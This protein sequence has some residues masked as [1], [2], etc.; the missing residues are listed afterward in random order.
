MRQHAI[1][2]QTKIAYAKKLL[3]ELSE[4]K[5]ATEAE[6]I[7]NLLAVIATEAATAQTRHLAYL[8]QFAR[9]FTELMPELLGEK[10][11]N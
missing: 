3:K 6:Q 9:N 10:A 7:G 8:E 1:T 2:A 4:A 11:G 5:T